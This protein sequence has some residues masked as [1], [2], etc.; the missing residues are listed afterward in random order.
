MFIK[1]DNNLEE[2][3]TK[4]ELI[5]SE[6]ESGKLPLESSLEKFEEGV[7]LYKNCKEFI[8]KAEKKIKILTDELKDE[9]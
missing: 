6:L 7:K 3:M 5:V 9:P 1:K 2:Y 8:L 4:L